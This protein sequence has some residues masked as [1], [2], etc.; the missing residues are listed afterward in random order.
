M[1][2]PEADLRAW[3]QGGIQLAFDFALPAGKR[4][5]LLPPREEEKEWARLFTPEERKSIQVE[6]GSNVVVG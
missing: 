6:L 5:I 1:G 3:L 2:I 4:H